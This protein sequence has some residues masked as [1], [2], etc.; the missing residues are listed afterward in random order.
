[1]PGCRQQCAPHSLFVL[2]KKRTGRARSKRKKRFGGSVRAGRVPPCRRRGKAG[3]SSFWLHQTR[4]PWEILWP[5]EGP[6]TL[7]FSFRWRCPGGKCGPTRASA[8]TG[9][10]EG[11]ACVFAWSPSS[12]HPR[13]GGCPHPPALP[14]PHLPPSKAQANEERQAFQ[15]PPR[16]VCRTGT[17][18]GRAE[19][20]PKS[21]ASR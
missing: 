7:C 16:S 17:R 10:Y 4:C 1:M 20:M 8:P 11:Q 6:D 15:Q 18:G 19:R 12:R 14:D 5:G 2:D 13:R 21:G 3:R 9:R